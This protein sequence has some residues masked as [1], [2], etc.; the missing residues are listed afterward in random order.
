MGCPNII[1]V[2]DHQTLSEVFVNRNLRKYTTPAS[3]S[4]KWGEEKTKK[5]HSDISLVSSF[6]RVNGIGV[7]ILFLAIQ[8]QWWKA[9]LYLFPTHY[10]SQ[11]VQQLSDNKD[12]IVESPIKDYDDN[13][14]VMLADF[15]HASGQN[16]K[17]TW[18][19]IPQ[20]IFPDKIWDP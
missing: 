19:P 1:V 15:I 7:L 16:D 12:D 18:I 10:F 5:K 6:T 3:L 11:E 13:E 20:Q 4:S 9:L 17:L 8:L 2:T 14:T